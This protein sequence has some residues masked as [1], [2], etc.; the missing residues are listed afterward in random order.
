MVAGGEP[1]PRRSH[2][3]YAD[4]NLGFAWLRLVAAFIV[5]TNHSAGLAMYKGASLVPSSWQ[6]APGHLALM[7]VFAMSG[8]QIS[9]SWQRDPSWWRF[10]ARRLLRILPPVLALVVITVFV[11]GS[12]YTTW[13]LGDYW[14]DKQTWRY[15]VGTFLVLLLQH[16]L[17]GV[18]ADNPYPYSVNGSIWTLPMELVGYGIVLI[19]GLLLVLR[20][21]RLVVLL[22]LTV[23]VFVLDTLIKAD[24][25]DAGSLIISLPTGPLVGYMVPFVLGMALYSFREKIPLRRF[26]ALVLFVAWLLLRT[27]SFEQFLLPIMAT[28]CAVV[29]AHH[30]PKQLAGSAP[31]VMGSYGTYLWG[32]P[33]Q[34]MIVAAGVRDPWILVACG[35]VAAYVC[36]VLSWRLVEVPSAR[37][38]KYLRKPQARKPSSAPAAGEVSQEAAQRQANRSSGSVPR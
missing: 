3:G 12:I 28:Y 29:V 4:R 33:V 34:Q 32:F 20:V 37:L 5:I 11:I 18:F 9:G 17:P 26:P 35:V 21:P 6:F 22:P 38:R 36:G 13:S 25:G 19:V 1:L 10:C 31:W 27:S 8:Y 16:D 23:G 14:A 24:G 30:W 2:S 15:L 7:V